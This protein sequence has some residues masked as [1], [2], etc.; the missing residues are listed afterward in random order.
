MDYSQEVVRQ[1]EVAERLRDAADAIERGEI[2]SMILISLPK[3]ASENIKV[4][5]TEEDRLKN[6]GLINLVL[7]RLCK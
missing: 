4:I 2:E 7:T 6:A 5:F 1:F 3:K